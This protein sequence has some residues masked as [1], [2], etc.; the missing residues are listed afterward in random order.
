MSLPPGGEYVG[1]ERK[2]EG[3]NMTDTDRER[4][5]SESEKR[6]RGMYRAIAQGVQYTEVERARLTGFMQASL[7]LGLATKD[8]LDQLVARIHL[9]ELGET[10]EQRR[11]H[12]GKQWASDQPDFSKYDSPTFERKKSK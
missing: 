7:F 1:K 11:N 8:E 4:I 9:E 12:K 5:A 10:L 6:L 3:R 2:I